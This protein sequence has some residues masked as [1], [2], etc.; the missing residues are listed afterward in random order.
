M[1]ASAISNSTELAG[2][3]SGLQIRAVTVSPY[4]EKEILQII[5]KRLDAARQQLIADRQAR[6]KKTSPGS[7]Q[8]RPPICTESLPPLFAPAALLL[9]AR[10]A[11]NANGDIRMALSG[12]WY[13]HVT[14]RQH[15]YT[16]KAAQALAAAA[17][18]G[19]AQ[20][21]PF[22]WPGNPAVLIF[23]VLWICGYLHESGSSTDA[24]VLLNCG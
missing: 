21:S 20:H 11:A 12:L 9:F 8:G 19:T 4:T 10:K 14:H 6:Y 5:N 17:T 2:H 23:C 1:C 13:G 7:S 3:L 22:C 16:L 15:A 24:L 18:A